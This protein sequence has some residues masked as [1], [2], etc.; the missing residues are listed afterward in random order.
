[1]NSVLLAYSGG[2]DSTFLLSL[3]KEVLGERVL[4]V[5]SVSPLFPAWEL[6]DARK[7]IRF[8][9]VKHIFFKSS[10][11]DS[12]M[13]NSLSRCYICKKELF[14]RLKKIA[15]SRNIPYVIDASNADDLNDFRPGR[16][17]LTDLSV[18]SPLQEAGFTKKEIRFFSRAR[19]LAVWNK[20]AYA[21]LASRIPY[22]ERIT[23]QKL[24]AIEAAEDFLHHRGFLQVRVRYHDGIA[25]IE[26]EN[27]HITLLIK[28]RNTIVKWFKNLG[29]RYVSLD[30]EG[31]RSG[32]MNK[33]IWKKRESLKF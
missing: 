10:L 8:L 11:R 21:C 24:K 30:M 23:L 3:A 20:P 4:A 9:K 12:V 16:L 5:T 18:R 28:K 13:C 2:V 31:Y 27:K 6:K 15:Q 1:M 7:F 25:R 33:G 14:Y 29:F 32:S 22:G 19:G 17:A 26:T